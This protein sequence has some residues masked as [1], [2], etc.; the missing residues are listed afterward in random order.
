M[1]FKRIFLVTLLLAG[2]VAVLIVGKPMKEIPEDELIVGVGV[3][4]N[5]EDIVLVNGE[6][7]AEDE[8]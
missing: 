6:I 1:N 4:V 2:V 5:W 8:L 7:L 3:G